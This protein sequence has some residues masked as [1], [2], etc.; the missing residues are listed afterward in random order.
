MIV[1]VVEGVMLTLAGCNKLFA[2]LSC[3]CL[4]GWLWYF[5]DLHRVRYSHAGHVCFGD[6]LG[7]SD[8]SG[9]IGKV[10]L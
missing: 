9:E 8:E 6:Y 7:V 10:Y 2:W 4:V 1:L 3:F 5:I